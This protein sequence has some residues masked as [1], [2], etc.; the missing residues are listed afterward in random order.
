MKNFF[1]KILIFFGLKVKEKEKKGGIL[2]PP[3]NDKELERFKK[4]PESFRRPFEGLHFSVSAVVT[5]E[6]RKKLFSETK[7]EVVLSKDETK[8]L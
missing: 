1:I 8:E 6:E 5:A 4:D 7:K 2:Y 3:M